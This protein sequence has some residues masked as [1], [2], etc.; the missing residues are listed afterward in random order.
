[1][2]AQASVKKQRTDEEIQLAYTKMKNELRTFGVKLTEFQS[3]KAEHLSVI[4][5]LN[6]QPG[7]KKTYRMIGEALVESTVKETLPKLQNQVTS[8][9]NLKQ[10][11]FKYGLFDVRID[12]IF[13]T[14]FIRAS[15]YQ[16]RAEKS[17]NPRVYAEV[18]LENTV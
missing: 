10:V 9:S 12:V 15:K 13:K 8:L 1:M 7:G 14:F 16:I 11:F 3:D 6:K 17:R 4:E 2:A 18:R 5:V